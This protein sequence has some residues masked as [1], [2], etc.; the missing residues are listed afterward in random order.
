[1]KKLSI[2]FLLCLFFIHKSFA[3]ASFLDNSFGNNGLVLVPAP[4]NLYFHDIVIRDDGKIVCAVRDLDNFIV[5]RFNSDG[6]VDAQFGSGGRVQQKESEELKNCVSLAVQPD[7]KILALCNSGDVMAIVRIN[8]DGSWDNSFGGN[9]VVADNIPGFQ[10][11]S[12]SKILLK[13]DGKIVAVGM[14]T[15]TTGAPYTYQVLTLQYNTDGTPDNTFGTAGVVAD[16]YEK[17]LVSPQVYA[18]LQKDGKIVLAF[19]RGLGM[20]SSLLVTR[21]KTDGMRDVLEFGTDGWVV[22]NPTGAIN[23]IS[24]VGLIMQSSGKVIFYERSDSVRS[25]RLNLNGTIDNTYG[26]NGTSSEYAHQTS[27]WATPTSIAV[28]DNDKILM[29]G[30]FYNTIST[31]Q[32]YGV[33]QFDDNGFIIHAFATNGTVY[34]DFNSLGDIATCLAVQKDEKIVAAGMSYDQSGHQYYS[35]AR[36]KPGLLGVGEI[37]NANSK[38]M[39][40][41]NPNSGTIR[42]NAASAVTLYITN[43]SGQILKTVELNSANKY[44]T[45][46]TELPQGINLIRSKDGSVFNKIITLQK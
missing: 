29:S 3:Q 44:T 21:Y 40:H 32:D 7:G 1:M 4:A 31:T 14:G 25:T 39:I 15:T 36:Y 38:I 11:G 33:T 28:Q 37:D 6:S 12:P 17:K 41:P 22:K 43:I 42:I 20:A 5:Y 9:G 27:F 45:T 24:P 26:V 30:D 23:T 13:P 18:V 2:L 19:D 16:Y 8:E 46:V 34:T 10:W 35:L